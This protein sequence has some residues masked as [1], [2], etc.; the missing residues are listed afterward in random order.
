MNRNHATAFDKL[1]T[2]SYRTAHGACY[3]GDSLD[4]LA[5]LPDESVDLVVTS[6]PF[7]LLRQKSYGN[8]DQGEYVDWL[9]AFGVQV[10]R[11][12]KETGSF[13]LESAA[14]GP[15][16]AGQPV[17]VAARQQCWR[18]NRALATARKHLGDDHP[19]VAA[20]RNNLGKVL[21]A[22]GDQ[23]SALREGREALRVARLQPDGSNSRKSIEEIWGRLA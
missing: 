23:A 6:P 15:D 4:L 9:C 11:V 8:K 18:V 19:G 21:K 12:L 7:A 1:P 13:V 3:Q 5:K 16:R 10:R 14:G 17:R 22:L 20:Y 2:A